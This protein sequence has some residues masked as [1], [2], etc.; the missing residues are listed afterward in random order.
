M[1]N[2]WVCLY[3]RDSMYKLI[4]YKLKPETGMEVIVVFDK[5]CRAFGIINT[6]DYFKNN[7]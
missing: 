3:V 6:G 4:M 1:A 5:E 2:V 7:G